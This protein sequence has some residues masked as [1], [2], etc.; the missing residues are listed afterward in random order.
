MKIKTITCHDVYNHGASLQAFALQTYLESLG[1]EVA[2]IDYKPS[3]L[4]GHFNLW[5]INPRFDKPVVRWLYY[6]AKLPGRLKYR[7]RKKPFDQFTQSY[8]HLTKRYNSFG[9][10]KSDPPHADIFVAGS[11][12]IWNSLFPNGRDPAFYLDFVPE[13]KKRI[14]YAASFGTEDIQTSIQPFVKDQLSRLDTISI[15]ESASLSL[16]D[17]LGVHNGIAVCDPVF[18]LDQSF[19][20]SFSSLGCNHILTPYLLV[21]DFDMS[22]VVR[23][24]AIKIANEK[25]L[26]IVSVSPWR[27]G[28]VE[29]N[30]VNASPIDFL[31]LI[32]RAEYVISNSFH[33]TAF[34]IIFQRDFCVI[35]RSMN[36]NIRMS[37][38]LDDLSLSDRISDSYDHSLLNSIS[39]ESVLIRLSTIVARSNNFL[40]A[41]IR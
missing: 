11:D 30:Y 15:R 16:L 23:E 6:L 29:K 1:H 22:P 28:Y 3:Y 25:K 10:L 41:A 4:N 9:E 7:R 36:L 13:G 35:E 38:L 32:S 39:Y 20:I 37:S 18:L 21:Y 17:S 12:Q 31:S 40:D 33:A 2:I 26:S 14:S 5:G 8:L 27:Y 24:V 34:S 19:W